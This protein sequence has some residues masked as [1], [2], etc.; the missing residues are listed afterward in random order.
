MPALIAARGLAEPDA[1]PVEDDLAT[2][3]L[4][5]AEDHVQ[6]GAAAGTD[7]SGESDDLPAAHLQ[8]APRT[9]PPVSSESVSSTSASSVFADVGARV[10]SLRPKMS[11][12]R[13][14]WSTSDRL[15]VETTSP[16]R[17]TVIVSATS[18]TSSR[19]WVTNTMAT[20]C[21]A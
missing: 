11:S 3:G 12:T 18:M 5:R 20:P 4:A 17:S 2:G 10:S 6:D 13:P 9:G 8:E 1:V 21:S 19:R 14:S 16:S 7:E 15:I